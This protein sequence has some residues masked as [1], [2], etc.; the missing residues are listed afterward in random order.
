M[1]LVDSD[2]NSRRKNPL[3]II[4]INIPRHHVKA[5]DKLDELGT[6]TSRSEGVRRAVEF[7]LKDIFKSEKKILDFLDDVDPTIV[8]VPGIEQPFNIILNKNHANRGVE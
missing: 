6:I 3:R 1:S 2:K 5:L 4:T 8:R 7:W